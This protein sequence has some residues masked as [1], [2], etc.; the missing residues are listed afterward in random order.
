ML[1]VGFEVAAEHYQRFMGKFADPLALA[2]L[3]SLRSDLGFH[4]LD[5]GAGTGAST[6]PLAEM[7]GPSAVAAVEPS[8]AFVTSLRQ[9]VSGLDVHLATAESI[10]FPD[11][12][13]DSA[14]AQLVVHFMT[15]PVLGISEMARVT[16]G[17]GMVAATVWDFAGDRAPLSLFWTAVRRLDDKV[18][19]ES[20]MPGARAGDLPRLFL[21]AGLTDVHEGSISVS[22]PYRDFDDWWEP[23]TLGVGPAGSYVANLLPSAQERLRT[24]C[25]DLLPPG[26]GHIAATTWM[27][28]G[29]RPR[30]LPGE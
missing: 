12:V 3:R 13:F 29:R 26:P 16:K 8:S 17:G 5:V 15:D 24:M 25:N 20:E 18:V 6:A 1:S 2:F 7:P 21:A 9:R 4:V 19:D 23:Y 14:L 11:G 28:T 10:P 30:A 22:V 27:A